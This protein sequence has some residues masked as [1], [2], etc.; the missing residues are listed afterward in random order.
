MAKLR[1]VVVDVTAVKKSDLF[2]ELRLAVRL[3]AV[4]A[5]KSAET[6]F[7]QRPAVVNL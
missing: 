4:S 1:M 3:L 7:R 6:I 2:T 5:A